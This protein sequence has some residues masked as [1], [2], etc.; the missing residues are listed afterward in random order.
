MIA[1]FKAIVEII[2]FWE[3]LFDVPFVVSD[4]KLYTEE[5]SSFFSFVLGEGG[6]ANFDG[7]G[8]VIV[9]HWSK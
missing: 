3:S 8:Q 7:G 5:D 2:E 4:F 1:I 9:I 6:D